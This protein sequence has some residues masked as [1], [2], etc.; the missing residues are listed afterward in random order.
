LNTPEISIVIPLFNKERE[1]GR[2]IRSVL[3]QTFNNYEII[4][5]NDGSTDKGPEI[6]RNI[7]DLRI[8]V[9]DQENGGV[10]V[11]RNRGINEANAE[12]I[13]FI[14]AD[15]EWHPDFL[16]TVI[17]LRTNYPTCDVFATNYV[18]RRMNNYLR[19]TSINGL[20][21]GFKEGILANYF[22]IAAKSD[23]PLWTSAIAINKKTITSI[24]GFPKGITSGEDLITW[25]KVALN[26]KIAY[27]VNTKAYNWEP[28]NLSDRPGRVPQTPDIVGEEFVRLLD[29]CNSPQAKDLRD[30][31][32]LWHQ[33]RASVFLRLGKRKEAI[34]EVKKSV[35][36]SKKNPKLYLFFVIALLP[37]GMRN[38]AFRIASCLNYNRRRI[39]I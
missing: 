15:D 10:S 8:R 16:E 9:I 23:P 17:R 31:I 24:G 3:A 13:A 35:R 32:A 2:A 34:W 26:H 12:L 20:P 11:A 14:D 28:V 29:A 36:Y 19:H 38:C 33:M 18:F 6:V 7:N 1:V 4:V 39:T 27:S 25:A 22:S 30:Y 21:D 5:L 37:R